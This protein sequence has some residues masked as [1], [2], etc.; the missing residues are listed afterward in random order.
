MAVVVAM[1]ERHEY[2][3]AMVE[4]SA[5]ATAALERDEPRAADAV[6]HAV[7]SSSYFDVFGEDDYCYC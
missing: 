6:D 7:G 4:I 2:V 3:P 1:E 5:T